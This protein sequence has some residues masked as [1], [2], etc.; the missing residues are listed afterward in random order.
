[1][2]VSLSLL[3]KVMTR[4]P[5]EERSVSYSTSIDSTNEYFA[6][7]AGAASTK[8]VKVRSGGGPTKNSTRFG[9][10]GQNS[11]EIRG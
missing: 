8:C 7:N 10:V 5:S 4:T 3:V 6:A 2:P 11:H 1:M 9:P